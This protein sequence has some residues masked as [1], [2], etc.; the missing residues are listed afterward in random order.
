MFLVVYLFRGE[1]MKD[2]AI[3]G[4][5]PVGLYAGTIAGLRGLS[6]YI[7]EASSSVG[8]QPNELYAQKN[9]A[10]FPGVPILTAGELVDKLYDQFKHSATG[11]ELLLNSQATTLKKLDGGFEISSNGKTYKVK[12]VLIAAGNGS[13]VPRTLNIPGESSSNIYYNVK[14]IADFYNKHVVIFGGGDSAVDWANMLEGKANVT[15]VHRRNEFRANAGA[16]E[17]LKTHANVH[18]PFSAVD[19]SGNNILIENTE[20]QEKINIPFDA[21]IVQYGQITG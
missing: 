7:F 17:H 1:K 4:A 21:I 9:V 3:I 19:I 5:G 15:L 11:I 2:I 20:T 12:T 18:T 6:G 16:V 10:D 13:S 14:D 8:G